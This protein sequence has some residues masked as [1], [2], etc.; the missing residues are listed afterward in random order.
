VIA[1]LAGQPRE[2]GPAAAVDRPGATTLPAIGTW[3]LTR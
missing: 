2:E 3:L 1:S